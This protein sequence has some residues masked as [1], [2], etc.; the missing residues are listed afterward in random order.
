MI[1]STSRVVENHLLTYKQ[2]PLETEQML[3]EQHGVTV[4]YLPLVKGVAP[5]EHL[6]VYKM[7]KKLLKEIRPDVVHVH[8][9][10]KHD[11]AAVE[12][13]ARMQGLV[14]V[15][16]PHRNVTPE[17][18]EIDFWSQKLPRLVGY[19]WLLLRHTFA[20]IAESEAEKA[21]LGN[22]GFKRR[23]E[24]L[25]PM[26][27]ESEQTEPYRQALSATYRKMM[28]S[29]YTRRLTQKEQD[30]V[31]DMVRQMVVD[32]D[33][34]LEKPS[35][36]GL[37]MRRIFILSYD[38]DVSEM[39]TQGAQKAGVTLPMP[40]DVAKLPRYRNTKAK[41]RVPLTEVEPRKKTKL[42]DGTAEKDAAMMLAR[43][44]AVGMER[45]TLRQEVEL[46]HLF[47]NADFDEDIVA[48][49][50]KRMGLKSFV[51]KLQKRLQEHFFLKRGYEIM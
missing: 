37:S 6:S 11:V 42:T 29:T 27:G 4:H 23:I 24:V 7:L 41:E 39:L 49:E 10:W 2:M 36:D 14:T 1:T 3:V 50:V 44:A 28:D 43:A 40:I 30:F 5:G 47:R 18:V 21:S 26:P 32:S 17:M 20:V 45:L 35:T 31:L 15:V 9:A 19:Q 13:I 48:A 12:L 22:V 51:K 38:E 46:Y 33:V 16:S 8:G 34:T 25:P